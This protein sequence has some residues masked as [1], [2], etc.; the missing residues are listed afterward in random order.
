VLDE[1][2]DAFPRDGN[3]Y[4]DDVLQLE[5]KRWS[6]GRVVLVGDA[7]G[8]VSLLA[9]QGASLAMYGAYVLAH[10]LAR[11]PGNVPGALERYEA[12]VRPIVSER[13]RAASRN[14][15]WFL[16]RTRVG[17]MLRDRITQ[18]ATTPPIA[19][20][21]SRRIGVARAPLD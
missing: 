17:K 11:E 8:C 2:L 16:P 19:W 20:M 10:E 9:G 6:V 21:L 3:V 1:L 7:A 14:V 15:S 12:R 5:A 13:Q 18:T 4:F